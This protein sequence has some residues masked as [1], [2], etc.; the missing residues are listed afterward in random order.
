MTK[1]KN[2]I[3]DQPRQLKKA[4]AYHAAGDFAEFRR[5]AVIIKKAESILIVGI[6]ASYNAGLAI[7]H[8]FNKQGVFAT[9][10]DASEFELLPAMPAHAVAIFLSRSGKSVELARSLERCKAAGISSVAI[11]ND[12]DSPLAK[13]VATAIYTSVDFDHA[14]SVATYTSIILV[15]TLL[16]LYCRDESCIQVEASKLVE[17][18]DAADAKAVGWQ[19]QI[20]KLDVSNAGLFSVFLGRG[21][22]VGSCHE[23]KLLWAEALKMPAACFTTGAFRHG[24]Q[25]LLR[26]KTNVFVWLSHQRAFENDRKLI[27]DLVQVGANVFV[28]TD[29]TQ[30]PLKGEVFAI[31]AVREEF[32]A[33]FNCLPI[34][35]LAEAW[36]HFNQTDCDS[37]RYCNY[38]VLKDQGLS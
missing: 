6:G 29:R 18:C 30:E 33:V 37:F 27:D 22:S 19:E 26:Q 15:G 9:V 35:L 28:M 21:E 36:S 10:S 8:A 23:G 7:A 38:I 25:E 1:F 17:A 4:L 13:N 31:P 2:N 14:V 5:A 20:R 11:T 16:A 12:L 3:L 32:Q 34:Q 24:P